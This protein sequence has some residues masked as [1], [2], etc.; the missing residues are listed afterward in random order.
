MVV[1]DP[2]YF[3]PVPTAG[4]VNLTSLPPLREYDL[5]IADPASFV[6]DAGSGS[7]VA[8]H[9]P[10]REFVLDLELV[11]APVAEGARAFVKNESGTFEVAPP[12]IWFFEGIVDIKGRKEAN[13]GERS[14]Y[15][16]NRWS[17]APNRYGRL[18]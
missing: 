9:L 6:A 10:G 3:S 16:E 12:R 2:A 1:T 13:N 4:E 14:H 7:L 18:G 8:L 17:R 5:V 11:P 15:R